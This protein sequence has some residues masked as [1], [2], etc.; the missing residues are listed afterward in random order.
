MKKLKK[1]SSTSKAVL[2]FEFLHGKTSGAIKCVQ[3]NCLITLSMCPIQLLQTRFQ[4]HFRQNYFNSCCKEEHLKG[5]RD[6]RMFLCT[7]YHGPRF[8]VTSL[9]QRNY[10]RNLFEEV[11]DSDFQR[12]GQV[13]L[14]K[15]LHSA[16][17]MVAPHGSL[18][19]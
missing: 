19:S 3:V 9:M 16:L 17:N 13:K 7:F 12:S 8:P 1:Q 11:W 10:F 15:F 18:N 2:T 5:N 6:C 14:A 4:L